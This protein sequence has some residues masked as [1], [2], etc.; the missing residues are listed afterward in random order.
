M[1]G[2]S[3]IGLR[4]IYL[5]ISELNGAP[6]EQATFHFSF[7]GRSSRYFVFRIEEAVDILFFGLK[8]SSIFYFSD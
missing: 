4:L 7:N 3:F 5:L 8:K 6:F 2:V 1:R